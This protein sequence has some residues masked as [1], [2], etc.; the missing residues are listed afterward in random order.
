M[1]YHQEF[2]DSALRVAAKSTSEI[3]MGAV[4][5]QG[6]KV[7]SSGFN[8]MNQTHPR[9]RRIRSLKN[10]HAELA[11]ILGIHKNDLKGCEV[12]VA[13]VRKSGASALAAPCEACITLLREVGCKKVV[14]TISDGVIG[15][16]RL[17]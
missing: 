15:E 12:Y 13:R 9:Y 8:K 14:F 10:I 17:Y 3:Q 2:I 1:S 11:C 5:T 4:L 16:T 6:R 7:I